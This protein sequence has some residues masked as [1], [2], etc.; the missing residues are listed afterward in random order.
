[1]KK[2]GKGSQRKLLGLA[3]YVICNLLVFLFMTASI[4]AAF[5]LITAIDLDLSERLASLMSSLEGLGF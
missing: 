1:M 5:Q 4:G 2:S 3:G